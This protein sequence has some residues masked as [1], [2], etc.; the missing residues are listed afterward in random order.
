MLEEQE[1]VEKAKR[2]ADDMRKRETQ[3]FMK[4][5]G[6]SSASNVVWPSYQRDPVLDI[7]REV[8]PPPESMFIGLG[9]DEDASTKRRHYRRF[10]PDELENIKEVLPMASPFQSYELKRG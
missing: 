4:E 3:K 5:K 9:W 7:D 1:R 2:N 8:N 6:G 10:Y